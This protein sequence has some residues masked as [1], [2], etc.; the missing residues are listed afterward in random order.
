[1][2]AGR[3]ARKCAYWIA[4][5]FAALITENFAAILALSP[6]EANHFSVKCAPGFVC[7]FN[8]EVQLI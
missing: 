1:M 6:Y 2:I 4:G 8:L 7:E 3:L 5:V